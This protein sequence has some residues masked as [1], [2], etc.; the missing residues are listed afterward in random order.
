MRCI[1]CDPPT[2]VFNE[3]GLCHPRAKAGDWKDALNQLRGSATSGIQLNQ[4]GH[5]F[6]IFQNRGSESWSPYAPIEGLLQRCDQ[7][8][9]GG[10]L[11]PELNTR[12]FSMFTAASAHR[13]PNCRRAELLQFK[14]LCKSRSSAQDWQRASCLLWAMRSRSLQLNRSQKLVRRKV[15][16]KADTHLTA[17]QAA[18]RC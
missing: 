12:Q 8:L 7:F 15:Q 11:L 18:I 1:S 10:H 14:M 6:S 17:G 3:Y 4:V 16:T 5:L 9:Q 2:I 13:H